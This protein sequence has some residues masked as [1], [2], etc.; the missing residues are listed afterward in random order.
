ERKAGIATDSSTAAELKEMKVKSAAESK[1]FAG[2]GEAIGGEEAAEVELNLPPK[3]KSWLQKLSERMS[4]FSQ[5]ISDKKI[6]DNTKKR[7][8]LGTVLFSLTGLGIG[9]ALFYSGIIPVGFAVLMALGPLAVFPI[10]Y[11]IY[12]AFGSIVGALGKLLGWID[13]HRL[14][15]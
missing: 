4:A 15:T 5:R 7:I 11:G 13:K 14:L 9:L 10:L 3:K 1:E 2:G 6:K 12:K 8:F